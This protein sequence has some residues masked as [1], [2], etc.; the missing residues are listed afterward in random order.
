MNHPTAL[1]SIFNN[2]PRFLCGAF[3][4]GLLS[5]STCLLLSCKDDQPLKKSLSSAE[6]KPNPLPDWWESEA[7]QESAR[8][9]LKAI[10]HA[11][12][13]NE[14]DLSDLVVDPS[15]TVIGSLRPATNSRQDKI[16][17]LTILGWNETEEDSPKSSLS[18]AFAEL[19]APWP[20]KSSPRL[21]VKNFDIQLLPGHRQFTT[22]T[23]YHAFSAGKDSSLQQTG[24]WL[25][26]WQ[27]D[28]NRESPPRLLT[29]RLLEL[30]EIQS[31]HQGQGPALVDVTTQLLSHLPAWHNNL[32]LGV[33]HWIPRLPRI[34]HRF[35]HG[36]A[37]GD[38][39][40]NGLEDL[41]LCQPEGLPNLLLL[42]Q[43]DG[44]VKE[45][46]AEFGLD[47]RDIS[48]SALFADF[49]NDGDQDLVV[50]FRSPLDIF[51]NVEGKFHRRHSLPHLGQIFNLAA[52]DPDADGL[53]DLY[54]CRYQN[55][56][57]KGR[58]PSAIPLHD[59]QNGGK[60]T[61]L[62]NLGS[63]KFE[64]V[65]AAVGLDE[66]NHRWTVA[67]AWEDYDRDGDLDLYCANDY[68]RNNLYRCDTAEDGTIS[69]H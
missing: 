53:L 39:D 1:V 11:L 5:L 20:D 16:D 68:G 7:T 55:L 17:R 27:L 44:T 21:K 14:L 32:K 45:A 60:N 48:T 9:Q 8:D 62:K 6:E 57:E 34:K 36:L 52:A 54:I 50:A 67:A 19:S 12:T 18:A 51:E 42:R 65:T 22:R 31:Q 26:H 24:K 66:N 37:I 56:D 43:A 2:V 63:W 40:Q 47:F 38:I 29:I 3:F 49:D 58:A 64:D 46:A 15:Q 59:A 13:Q 69:F 4:Y 28:P 25:C 41:Y 10:V 33:N 61:L 30:E 23:D 35:Q